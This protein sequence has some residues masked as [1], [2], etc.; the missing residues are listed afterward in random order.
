MVL[1]L[2]TDFGV[3]PVISDPNLRLYFRPQ[4]SDQLIAGLGAPKDVEPLDIDDYDNRLDANTRQRIERGLFQRVPALRY[5]DYVHGWASIYT[6]SD[7]WHPLV[8]SEPDVE[9]YYVCFAGSGHGFKLAPPIGESLADMIAGDDPRTD[10]RAFRPSRFAEGE[11][12]TT[13][14]GSGN[15]G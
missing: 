3:F 13:A 10:L 1:R 6:I 8:G 9:G 4:G 7:D 2:P 15:R 12:I 5:A 11:P 14:W